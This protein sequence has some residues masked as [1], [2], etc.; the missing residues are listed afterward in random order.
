MSSQI[1]DSAVINNKRKNKKRIFSDS[2][3]GACGWDV[4]LVSSEG[5]RDF[6]R[7]DHG[8]FV[9]NLSEPSE[10][11]AIS[12]TSRSVLL[13]LVNPLLVALLTIFVNMNTNIYIN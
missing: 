6:F 2:N 11:S 7:S 10:D 12:P 4:Q 1:N 3:G 9:N 13:Y 8:S 5:I